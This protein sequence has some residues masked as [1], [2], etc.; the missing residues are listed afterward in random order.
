MELKFGEHLKR[1]RKVT[2]T[3]QQD[4]ADY[5]NISV[6]SVSKWETG[7]ALPSVDL[8]AKMAEF[9]HSSV[10]VFFSEYE[11]QIYEQFERIDDKDLIRVYEAML[12][13]A[14]LLRDEKTV[15]LDDMEAFETWPIE[16][17]FLP[18]LYEYLKENEFISLSSLQ[19]SFQIGYGL[20]SKIF[21]ALVKLGVV[22]NTNP[23]AGRKIIKEKIDLLLPYLQNKL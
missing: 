17:M 9:Y 2:K 8:L 13:Q 10:N 21:D 16:S 1:V 12:M 11:L 23:E 6:Q 22:D 19:K 15:D 3:T 4:L 5:L 7:L 20:A 18:A 14:G